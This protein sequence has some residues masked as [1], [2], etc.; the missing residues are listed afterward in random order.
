MIEP[1]GSWNGASRQLGSQAALEGREAL[2]VG[3]VGL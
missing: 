3:W 1:I 2:G